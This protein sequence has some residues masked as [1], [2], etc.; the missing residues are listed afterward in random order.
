MPQDLVNGREDRIIPFRLATGYRDQAAQA[1][2]RV[3]L[4][5]VPQTGHVELVTPDTPAWAKARALV[6][7]AL[8]RRER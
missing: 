7:A 2:D 3:T 5:T 4:H 8:G 1:G 6:L